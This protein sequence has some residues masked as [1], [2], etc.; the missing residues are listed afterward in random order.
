MHSSPCSCSPA[1][2]GAEPTSACARWRDRPRAGCGREDH[3]WEIDR[4]P[5]VSPRSWLPLLLWMLLKFALV[6]VLAR[7][8]PS[9]NLLRFD[10]ARRATEAEQLKAARSGAAGTKLRR[11]RNPGRPSPRSEGRR[12]DQAQAL[13][14]PWS[15]GPGR[16]ISRRREKAKELLN[17][18]MI[19]RAMRQRGDIRARSWTTLT[20]KLVG[21]SS[22]CVGFSGERT[23]TRWPLRRAL[24]I[25][26]KAGVDR[27]AL[28]DWKHLYIFRPCTPVGALLATPWVLPTSARC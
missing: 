10:L 8:S 25:A 16:A 22:T 19:H 5:H 27:R 26:P 9:P 13:A 7:L 4:R 12:R 14:K 6:P 23:P 17:E 24:F 20:R 2:S 18:P 11:S 21:E 28:E 15:S 3:S 1:R